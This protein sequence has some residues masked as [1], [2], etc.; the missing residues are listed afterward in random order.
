MEKE[1]IE[2]IIGGV[3]S[4]ILA[5]ITYFTTKYTERKKANEEIN[6]IKA[7]ND[8]LEEQYKTQLLTTNNELFEKFSKVQRNVTELNSVIFKF[9]TDLNTEK[10]KVSDLQT[11]N[12]R[13]SIEQVSQKKRILE[14]E[15]ENK[16]LHIEL[17]K[18]HQ[19]IKA[20]QKENEKLINKNKELSSENEQL[21]SKLKQ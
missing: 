21:K 12:K 5:I 15:R 16:D 13:L 1:Y 14:L 20:L 4:I 11:D 2:V 3:V 6:N 17:E 18:H 9:Q 7:Q 8:V 10:L 19:L